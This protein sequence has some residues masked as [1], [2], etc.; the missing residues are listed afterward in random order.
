MGAWKFS[1]FFSFFVI[2]KF[3]RNSTPKIAKVVEFTLEKI[4]IPNLSIKNYP[5][6]PTK[7]TL[8]PSCPWGRGGGIIMGAFGG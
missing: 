6:F 7:K 4:K 3:W 5:N 2:S 8:I 1:G